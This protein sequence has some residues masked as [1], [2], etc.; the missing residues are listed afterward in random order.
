MNEKIRILVAEDHLVARVGVVTIVNMQPDMTVVAE[1][2]NGNQ[3]VE[4][5]RAHQPDVTLLDLRMPGMGGVEA[6]IAIRSEFPGAHLIALTTYGG[7]EDIRRALAAGVQAYL[8]KDVLHDELLKA[9]RAVHAGQTY[10]PAAVAASLAAQLPRPDL[11]ARE[12]QVLGLI[13]RGLANKQI[14]FT[15]SIAEHTV[16]NHVKNILS[17]LGVQDRTQAATAAIQRGIIHL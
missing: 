6:A 17:K 9:I 4:M 14:A 7:D 16:K 8:T 1:A 12:V 10:L 11:S 15:L 13:V 5:F 2:A 3:A